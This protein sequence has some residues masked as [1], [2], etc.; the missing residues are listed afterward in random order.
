[1]ADAD[2]PTS[3]ADIALRR[4][5]RDATTPLMLTIYE[6]AHA[7]SGVGDVRALSYGQIATRAAALAR[8]LG[9]AGTARGEPIGCYL[10]NSASW[11][12]A[13][14]AVWW[15]G[16]VVAAAG[17]LLPG[18]EA[19][20][21]FDLA[22]VARVVTVQD[23]PALPGDRL[24]FRLDDEGLLDGEPERDDR[25]WEDAALPLPDADDVA[26]AIFTS[27]T[28]GRP[29]GVP[30]T[31]GDLVLAAS[32]VAAAYAR[33]GG[34]RPEPAPAHLAP[35]VLFNPFGHM[36]GY[37]RLAF[38]MWIGRSLVLVPK[39]SVAAV[40]ALCARYEMDSLQLTPA[41]IHML[42]TDDDSIDLRGVKYVT[43]GTAPLAVDTRER[44]EA[45]YGVP[46]MQAYGSTELG[47]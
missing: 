36:A 21:L 19:D 13:S 47:A 16:G 33:D 9:D 6:Q 22:G 12:V 2:G 45:R 15:S 3:L 29:K 7:R 39:F 20:R 11:V 5:R 18:A 30:H 10:P 31:H 28:T 42:A 38:R 26:V 43:S 37:S 24:V 46:V 17:T 4:A 32:S 14:L 34:Y 27:G 23:A 1:M 25:G 35:G 40:R 8:V 44:F 41:M